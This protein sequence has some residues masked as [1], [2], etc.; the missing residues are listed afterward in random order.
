[1]KIKTVCF[2]IHS[3]HAGGME[4]VM[5]EL[6]NYFAGDK[7]YKVHLILYGVK[8]EVFYTISKDITIHKP[9]FEFDNNSRFFS[10]IKT[11]LFLRK[12]IKSIHPLSVLSFGERWN[13]MVLLSMLG[14]KTPIYVSDRAQPDK[15]LGSLHDYLRKWLYPKA[16]GVIVQ[17]EKALEIFQKMYRHTNFKIIGNP[18]RQIPE[19]IIEKENIILMVG[20]YIQSKQ[21]DVLI[22]IFSKVK[23]PNWKLVLVGYNHLKQQN[24]QQW[25]ALAKKLHIADRVIFTGKQEDVEQYYLSSKIFA[26]SSASEGFPNVIGEAMSTELPIVAFDCIAGPSDLVKNGDNGF[27]IPL[28]DTELF[29]EKLQFL[30]DTPELIGTMGKRSKER[31]AKFELNYICSEFENFITSN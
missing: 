21:Q 23:A 26:F 7:N 8:R 3:L 22:R 5:S 28:N 19:R 14:T 20:R 30:I 15:S 31:I 25:E 18:I 2:V 29:K 10:T 12:K 13:N 1:M 17:T 16:T 4:R 27:L 6:L 11:L 9:H 24:Q